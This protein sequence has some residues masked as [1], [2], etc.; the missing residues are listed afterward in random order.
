M[1]WCIVGAVGA[2]IAV[3]YFIM[4]QW[5]VSFSGGLITAGLCVLLFFVGTDIGTEGTIADSFRKAGW[6]IALFPI[7]VIGEPWPPLLWLRWCFPWECGT[8]SV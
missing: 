5:I 4:P 1:T 7:A 3:G 2:G 6:R 8:L